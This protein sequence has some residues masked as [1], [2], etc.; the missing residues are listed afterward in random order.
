MPLTEEQKK[1]V[2]LAKKMHKDEQ[3]TTALKRGRAELEE[4]EEE[5][6]PAEKRSAADTSVMEAFMEVTNEKK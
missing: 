6:E 3:P 2:Q 5:E 4:E 1:R